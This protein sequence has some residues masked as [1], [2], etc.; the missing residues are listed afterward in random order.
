M[1]FAGFVG[2]RFTAAGSY[3]IMGLGHMRKMPGALWSGRL[4]N[5]RQAGRADIQGRGRFINVSV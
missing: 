3:G 4:K 5:A 1:W 2:K